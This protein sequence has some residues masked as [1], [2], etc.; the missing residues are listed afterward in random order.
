MHRSLRNKNLIFFRYASL[1][2]LLFLISILS[3]CSQLPTVTPPTANNDELSQ[4]Q[5]YLDSWVTRAISKHKISAVSV[6]L[7]MDDNILYQNNF[8]YS[9]ARHKE[10]LNSSHKFR[11]ASLAK[12]LNA[13]AILRLQ[14]AGKLNLETPITHYLPKFKNPHHDTSQINLR[15]LLSHQAGLPSDLIQGMWEPKAESFHTT[16]DYL[17][18]THYPAQPKNY[19][20][21]SNLAFNLIAAVIDSISGERYDTYMNRLLHELGMESSYF[22]HTINDSAITLG[23]RSKKFARMLE[24][25]DM[26]AAGLI[27]NGDDLIKLGIALYN[28]RSVIFKHNES[29]DT[30]YRNHIINK[31]YPHEQEVGLGIFKFDD[32]FHHRLPV[33]GHSGASLHHRSLIKFS[34]KSKLAVVVLSNDSNSAKIIHQVANE[35]LREAYKYKYKKKPPLPHAYWPKP[36]KQDLV[37]TQL[38][39]G[40]WASIFGYL[41]VEKKGSK[42][43]AKLLG[44]NFL[45][46]QREQ[47]GL[48]YLSYKLWGIFPIHLGKLSLLGFSRRDIGGESYLVSTSTLGKSRI[49]ARQIEPHNVPIAWRDRAGRYDL[50][51]P[52]SAVSITDGGLKFENGL[53][54]AYGKIDKK[55][56]LT[57]VLEP[58]NDTEAIVSGMGRGFNERVYAKEEDGRE[59]LHYSNMKFFAR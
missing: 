2:L 3:A 44:K 57:I 51:K 21:Y 58:V 45:L 37:S 18:T 27:S 8:G 14:E 24:I 41:K 19:Y 26:P 5:N 32:V 30:L 33:Y 53:L 42:L 7:S 12:L 6:N 50:A 15:M 16:Q 39:T 10:K 35:A 54:L 56:H 34:P 49:I 38:L 46:K 28:R 31:R 55:H 48:Y 23:H 9:D 25:R 36:R 59:L 52:L 1:T 22:S 17:N 47:N 4:L 43:Q 29:F 40:H 11:V 20:L 13:I